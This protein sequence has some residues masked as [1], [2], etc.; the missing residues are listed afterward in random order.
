M[1]TGALKEYLELAETCF[2]NERLK[3]EAVCYPTSS[4]AMEAVK[5]GEVDCM[6][7]ANLTDYDGETQGL[8]MTSP[9]MRT[10]ML[11]IVAASVQK[12]FL[13]KDR[14][15]CAVNVGNPN[16]RGCSGRGLNFHCG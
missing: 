13:K 11:A 8:F 2:K 3:F 6:F 9:L 15:V 7:P 14:V 16:T 12:A 5:S 10:E 4:A 1:F